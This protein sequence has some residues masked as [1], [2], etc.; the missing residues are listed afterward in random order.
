MGYTE[1]YSG[2]YAFTKQINMGFHTKHPLHTTWR[3]MNV[4]CYDTRHKAY[5]RYGGRGVLVCTEWR[6]DNP[7]G[8]FNF[9]RDVGERPIGTTLDRIDNDKEYS[10]GNCKWST[11]KEQRNNT[12][13]GLR[14]TSGEMGVSF[15]SYHNAWIAQ[16]GLFGSTKNIGIFN[17]E[18]KE[19]AIQRYDAVKEVKL[20][21]DDQA[22]YDYYLSIKD[23]TPAGKQKRRNKTSQYYGVSKGKKGQWRA[24]TNEYV[25]GKLKQINLGQHENELD[26]Y[27]AVL[28]RLEETKEIV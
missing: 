14:N 21:Q 3:M 12:G 8:L 22:A 28:K 5:H 26:A 17:I 4:R 10:K 6:W 16:I 25:D 15:D 13:I 9:V 27:Q 20:E 18:D 7:L 24:F 2:E 23:L 19:L 1:K 11:K